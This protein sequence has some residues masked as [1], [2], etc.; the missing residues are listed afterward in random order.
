[1]ALLRS[2]LGEYEVFATFQSKKAAVLC[3]LLFQA[4]RLIYLVPFVSDRILYCIRLWWYHCVYS[5]S[6]ENQKC[7]HHCVLVCRAIF[8]QPT[9]PQSLVADVHARQS[10][11]NL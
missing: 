6:T 7:K 4:M 11:L 8:K 5:Y 1:M 2:P 9:R 10:C 3:I